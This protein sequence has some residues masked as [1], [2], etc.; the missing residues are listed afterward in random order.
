[1]LYGRKFPI[2]LSIDHI[3]LIGNTMLEAYNSI[4]AERAAL[5]IPALPLSKDQ[6]AELVKLLKNPP[7]EKKPSTGI[8]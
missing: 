4:A 2:S 7:A 8:R 6:T 3:Y 1:M 5:G